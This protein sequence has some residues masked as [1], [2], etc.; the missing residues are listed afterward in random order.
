M[1]KFSLLMLIYTC[2]FNTHSYPPRCTHCL[3][4]K[5]LSSYLPT[6]IILP[7]RTSE[8]DFAFI[9][10]VW[11]DKPTI[12]EY[13]IASRI[14][15]SIHNGSED[16]VD[17][18]LVKARLGKQKKFDTNIIIHHTY[19]KRLQSDK[20]A[21]HQLWQQTFKQTAVLDTR[22]IIGNRNSPNIMG[23]LGHQRPQP[24]RPMTMCKFA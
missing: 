20:K 22:L 7:T 14:A 16:K 4:N 24:W 12:P 13:Q 17:N 5:F 2:S 18:P 11:L 6:S 9:R 15:K 3:S 10:R 19:E 21:S 1:G 23:E 8:N